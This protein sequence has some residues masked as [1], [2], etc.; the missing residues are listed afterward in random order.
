MYMY[1]LYWAY[2]TNTE[3]YNNRSVVY[4]S[5]DIKNQVLITYKNEC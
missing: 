3:Y 1:V 4:L 5:F 2:Y